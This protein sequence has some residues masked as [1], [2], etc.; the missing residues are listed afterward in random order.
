MS[1][2]RCPRCRT[3]CEPIIAKGKIARWHGDELAECPECS[4]A[5]PCRELLPADPEVP[6]NER[7]EERDEVDR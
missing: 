2:G 5:Y 6:Y 1:P 7:A 3:E 4:I